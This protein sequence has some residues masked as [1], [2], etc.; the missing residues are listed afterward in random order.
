MYSDACLNAI[1]TFEMGIIYI[2]ALPRSSGT[3]KSVPGSC[4]DRLC[5]K[6]CGS[7]GKAG[8]G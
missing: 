6:R 1:A 4:L 3:R 2:G 7:L 5:G 8:G